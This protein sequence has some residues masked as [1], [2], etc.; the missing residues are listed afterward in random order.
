MKKFN[1]YNLTYLVHCMLAKYKCDI[2]MCWLRRK[3]PDTNYSTEVKF[4]NNEY[5]KK[6]IEEFREELMKKGW[7][8]NKTFD[9]YLDHG[10]V[11]L[12]ISDNGPNKFSITPFVY[13]GKYKR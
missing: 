12:S 11:S 8:K 6:C 1:R 13:S 2:S 9:T 4:A 10:Y 7:T 3:Y 5:G